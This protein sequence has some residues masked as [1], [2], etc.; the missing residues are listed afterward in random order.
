MSKVSTIDTVQVCL[1]NQCLGFLTKSSNYRRPGICMSPSSGRIWF[2]R[3]HCP[4]SSPV[5]ISPEVLELLVQCRDLQGLPSGE[6]G[7][8]QGATGIPPLTCHKRLRLWE[9]GSMGSFQMKKSL[10]KRNMQRC[11]FP[12]Q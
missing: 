1:I 7:W 10:T 8:G 11:L 9:L 2:Q 6:A 4:T 3:L 12:I 5:L